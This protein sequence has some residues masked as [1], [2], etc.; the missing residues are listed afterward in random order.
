MLRIHIAFLLNKQTLL[1]LILSVIVIT[2]FF[3][4][5]ADIASGYEMLDGERD[6]NQSVYV[7]DSVHLLEFVLVLV[8]SAIGSLAYSETSS[9][10]LTYLVFDR[11]TK[12]WAN[13][14]KSLSIS[15]IEL[16]FVWFLLLMFYS[17]P[18]LFTPFQ[19]SIAD[20]TKL[21]LL[22]YAEMLF[23]TFLNSLMMIIVKN[24]LVLVIPLLLFFLLNQADSYAQIEASELLRLANSVVVNLIWSLDGYTT[25]GDFHTLIFTSNLMV[26]FSTFVSVRSDI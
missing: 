15:L 19:L 10:Y 18:R 13:I 20:I 23:Y 9:K 16:G 17:I 22:L 12:F 5:Y 14:S 26:M 24:H 8:G 3:V 6:Y 11:K 21:F 1:I 25:Y 4:Y 2:G 7:S